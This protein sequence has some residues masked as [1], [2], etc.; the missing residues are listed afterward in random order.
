MVK[1][2]ESLSVLLI[3]LPMLVG[4]CLA[5]I[6][7]HHGP[8]VGGDAT[9]Y[10]T[11][12]KNLAR[13]FG[14]VLFE[15]D[16]GARL[17]PY[18]PPFYPLLLSLFA[19][20]G[21]DLVQTA[22]WLNIIL[23]GAL[24]VMAGTVTM[25]LTKSILLS[26]LLSFVLAVSPVLLPVYSWAMSEP[27]AILLGFASL[28][29]LDGKNSEISWE[30][31]FAS[32]LLAGLSFLTRYSSI[33][34]VITGFGVI[35]WSRN[36]QKFNKVIKKSLVYGAAALTPMLI[37]LIIDLTQTST[38]ASRSMLG[39]TEMATRFTGYLPQL[40]EVLLFWLLPESLIENPP[41]PQTINTV[42]LLA[43]VVIVLILAAMGSKGKA[44]KDRN[45]FRILMVF[46][47]I[48]LLVITGIYFTTYPPI[49]IGSRMFSPLHIAVLWMVILK[50]PDISQ[51]SKRPWVKG[52]LLTAVIF[53]IAVYGW[54][55]LR[56]VKYNYDQGLGYTSP[57]WRS[58]ETIAAMRE[59]P[60]DTIL[61]TNET[62]A[63]LFL[64]DRVSYPLQEIYADQPVS[65][66]VPYGSGDVTADNAQKLFVEQGA[67]LVLFDTIDNQ[68]SG[69]YHDRTSERISRLVSGLNRVFRGSDG[70]IFYYD[71]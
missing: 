17:L 66:F 44:K 4:M 49:T 46:S 13:G 21:F 68:L 52:L 69:L 67:A 35:L 53:F 5:A 63:V 55:T 64:A 7:M 18:F 56:I 15:P 51:L 45:L 22:F 57:A 20:I 19:L 36:T 24:I 16:G 3:I 65:E 25:K 32:G 71:H 59:I 39:W 58:S 23:F 8:G 40:K 62:N 50:L 70:G 26:S 2:K 14:L 29:L 38:V 11:T 6:S 48:Y 42:M 54:R 61:I 31:L 60:E 33:A 30:T 27:L 47:A 41:Y 34:F 43:V 10:L 37:W 9:I 28:V 12:A 1:R